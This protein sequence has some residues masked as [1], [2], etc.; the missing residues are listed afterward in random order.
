MN[1]EEIFSQSGPIAKHLD[2]YEMRKQQV[3]MAKKIEEVIHKNKYLIVEAGTG[4][5]KSFAYIVPLILNH[6]KDEK[7]II[8]TCSKTLQDQLVDKDLPFLKECLKIPF[9]YTLCVGSENYVCLRRLYNLTSELKGD[10][11]KDELEQMLKWVKETDTGRQKDIDDEDFELRKSF[12]NEVNR[13]PDLCYKKKC[14]Y[15]DKC[16]YY[17]AKEKEKNADILVSNHHLFFTNLVADKHLLPEYHTIVFDEAHNIENI[18]T[19]FF[20]TKISQYGI[21]KKLLIPIHSVVEKDKLFDLKDEKNERI[22]REII[23]AVNNVLERSVVFFGSI[24]NRFPN[25]NSIRIKQPNFCEYPFDILLSIISAKLERLKINNTE[26]AKYIEVYAKRCSNLETNLKKFIGQTEKDNVYLVTIRKGKR[27]TNVEFQFTPIDISSILHK[28]VF[29]ESM[30][31]ILTSATLS[32]E[33][34][35][36]FLKQRIGIKQCEELLLSSPFDFKKQVKLYVNSKL[37]DPSLHK[38]EFDEQVIS[39]VQ[40]LVNITKRSTMVLFTSYSLL[41]K[42]NTLLKS[43]NHLRIST[44]TD[45]SNKTKILE[46]LKNR[47]IDVLL[48]V[49]SFWQGV[50]VPGKALEFL[51]IPKLPFSVPD[52]PIIEARKE[53][54][55]R[56]GGNGFMDYILPM[57]VL[58]FK[59]GFG[60]LIRT[61]TDTGIAMVLDPRILTKH[62]GKKFLNSLPECTIINNISDIVEYVN[63]N[64]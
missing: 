39:K 26:K 14:L 31:I 27:Y 4:S 36:Y 64:N 43:N 12:W 40:E 56:K 58:Y 25:K 8:T 49:S 32:V 45:F 29:S 38:K 52:D 34:S 22:R 17:R 41:N 15:N 55:E 47:K 33:G 1:I 35:F 57:A 54:V 28:E 48:G 21:E 30:P 9:E 18:A 20:S 23:D 61:K 50:D 3:I 59:Q 11:T 62:Y 19:D 7:I 63:E 51:I 46:D 2:N 16:F 53:Y 13:D 44:Q 60:R 42:A 5:G 10:I 6:N 37:P 24:L